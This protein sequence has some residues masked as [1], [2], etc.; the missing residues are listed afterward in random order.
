MGRS[1]AGGSGESSVRLPHLLIKSH[2]AIPR[3]VAKGD[4]VHVALAICTIGD[5]GFSRFLLLDIE[6]RFEHWYNYSSA[7][8]YS[9]VQEE[10]TGKVYTWARPDGSRQ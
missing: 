6:G 1:K 5:P 3:K 7:K 2:M 8:R 4:R 9:P 10:Q